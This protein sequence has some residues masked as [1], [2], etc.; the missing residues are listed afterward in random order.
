MADTA[1][2]VDHHFDQPVAYTA[3]FMDDT[4]TDADL[5]DTCTHLDTEH[6]YADR[7]FQSNTD[8]SDAPTLATKGR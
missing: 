5:T 1:P 7:A 6:P 3:G 2:A 4:L 8:T